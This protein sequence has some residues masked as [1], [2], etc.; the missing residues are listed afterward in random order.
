MTNINELVI[1]IASYG[2]SASLDEICST[3]QRIH[4]KV[5]L[6]QHKALI[7]Q[8]LLSSPSRVRYDEETSKW[9]I[10]QSTLPTRSTESYLRVSDNKYFNTIA[11]AMLYLFDMKV[12]S[13]KAFF[14]VK[15]GIYAWFPQNNNRDWENSLSED[16]NIWSERPQN[17]DPDFVFTPNVRYAFRHDR[18]GYRFTG[19]FEAIP[20]E[21]PSLRTYRKIDDK[22]LIRSLKPRMVVCRLAYM[23]YY[24]GINANDSPEN[25][26]SFV[27]VTNDASEKNNFHVYTDG[28]CYGFVETKYKSGHTAESEYAKAIALEKINPA[29]RNAGSVDNVLVVFVAYNSDQK[30][31]LIVGWYDDATIYRNRIDDGEKV[32]MMK[33]LSSNAHRIPHENRT[34]EVPKATENQLGIGQSNYWYIQNNENAADLEQRIVAYIDSK[35]HPN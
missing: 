14:Q 13:Y 11:E 7:K 15:P 28:Y 34:F 18:E 22:V 3:Y 35:R 25:G 2:D 33:C 16:G 17:P 29:A 26:G 4:R 30:K 12:S 21:S 19:L 31:T 9:F 32:Y 20:P 10:G 8:C 24:D 6:P 27:A 1:I 23:K 5:L